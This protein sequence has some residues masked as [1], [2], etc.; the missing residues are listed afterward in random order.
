[1]QTRDD[2][3]NMLYFNQ[4]HSLIEHISHRFINKTYEDKKKYLDD[5]LLENREDNI[6]WKMNKQWCTD[7]IKCYYTVLKHIQEEHGVKQEKTINTDRSP[8]IMVEG[9]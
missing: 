8:K 6:V 9:W 5:L 4:W 2:I 7:S 1:M 3:L